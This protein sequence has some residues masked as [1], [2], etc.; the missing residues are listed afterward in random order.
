MSLQV[1]NSMSVLRII[2]V[3]IMF[4]S[5]AVSQKN[6]RRQSTLQV[7][8]NTAVNNPCP[9]IGTS[10]TSRRGIILHTMQTCTTSYIKDVQNCPKVPSGSDKKSRY[11]YVLWEH[12]HNTVK[13]IELYSNVRASPVCVEKGA[14]ISTTSPSP[15]LANTR[16]VYLVKGW[17]LSL[18]V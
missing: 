10:V 4:Y 3:M 11:R 8:W 17:I 15:K 16:K 6:T 12:R 1:S 5:T 2:L 9:L 13:T 14:T 7:P 18:N